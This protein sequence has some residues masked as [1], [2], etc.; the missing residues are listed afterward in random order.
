MSLLFIAFEGIPVL[1]EDGS[2]RTFLTELGGAVSGGGFSPGGGFFWALLSGIPA[3]AFYYLGILFLQKSIRACGVGLAGAM[4][5]MGILVPMTLSMLIWRDM[6]T[7]VQW[8]GILLA[9]GAVVTGSLGGGS[10][11]GSPA[12]FRPV[13]LLLFLTVGMAEFSNKLYQSCGESDPRSLFL[14]T[15]FVTALL[16][17]TARTLRGRVRPGRLHLLIGAAVGVPNFLAS[18]FLLGALSEMSAL[19]VFPVYG[20][21][22]ICLIALFGR[23]LFGERLAP[24]ERLSI[25]LAATAMVFVNIRTPG[26]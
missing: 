13:L 7:P 21:M 19:V 14:L 20:A 2:L 24:R 4:S 18:F 8:V 5:R 6:P 17:S 3:G 22:T 23:I 1:P 10:S 16:L 25:V 9:L 15:V 26:A 11:R 12:G